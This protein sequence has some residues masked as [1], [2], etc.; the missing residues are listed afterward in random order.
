MKKIFD[1][2]NVHIG[3]EIGLIFKGIYDFFEVLCGILLIFLTPVR[4]TKL[5]SWISAN[6]LREDPNDFV[7][8]HLI[9]FSHTFSISMQNTATLYLLSHGTV[10][11]IILFLLWKKKLWA[12]PVSCVLFLS[13]VV[14]QMQRFFTTHS[15]TLIFLTAIDLIMIV[16]TLLEYKNLK[17]TK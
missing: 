17:Q 5:I 14:I 1:K 6:E 8:K 3:F 11:L 2:K 4:M 10:K 12:Y 13:F 15:I 9:A 7:M 16:L